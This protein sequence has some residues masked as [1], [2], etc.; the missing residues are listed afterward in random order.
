MSTEIKEVNLPKSKKFHSMDKFL[1]LENINLIFST[2]YYVN[3][4]FKNMDLSIPKGSFTSI[5]GASGS[6]KTSLL[7]MI[8]GFLKPNSGN[9]IYQN[10]GIYNDFL[11]N[12]RKI[13]QMN[14]LS[15]ISNPILLLETSSVIDNIYLPMAIR[16]IRYDSV[17]NKIFSMLEK[18]EIDS[19]WNKQIYTLSGGEKQRVEI[20]RC[21]IQ[22]NPILIADEPTSFLNWELSQIII[23]LLQNLNKNSNRTI[24]LCSHD[25]EIYRIATTIYKIKNK[26]LEKID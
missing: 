4:V 2:Q 18:L 21:L 17:K 13:Y 15:I 22:E 11:N 10:R 26:K 19:L 25:P 12:E 23:E 1:V 7:K 20:I 5:I 3:E 6:G 16:G 14:Q 9:I 8:S 24:I